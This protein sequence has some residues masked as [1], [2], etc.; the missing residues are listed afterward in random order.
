MLPPPAA[1]AAPAAVQASTRVADIDKV[2]PSDVVAPSPN[3]APALRAYSGVWSGQWD[4]TFAVAIIV[5][6]I[7][8]DGAVNITYRWV[9][10]L[11]DGFSQLEATGKIEDGT[12]Y[13]GPN[14]HELKLDP[15]NPMMANGRLNVRS[16]NIVRTSSFRKVT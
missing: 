6:S 13:F 11:G 9:E 3:V 1:A 15:E 16:R 14:R 8:P 5:R 7:E 4:N 10:R 2:A 12:L